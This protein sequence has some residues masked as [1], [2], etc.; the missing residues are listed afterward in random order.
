M[1]E[2]KQIADVVYLQKL[3]L[4]TE[5]VTL[6]DHAKDN[7]MKLRTELFVTGFPDVA[8]SLSK[9]GTFALALPHGW[10]LKAA[11]QLNMSIDEAALPA[12]KEK[13]RTMQVNVDELFKYKPS[14][15]V[16]KY[17]TLTKESRDVLDVILT[18]KRGAVKLE[19]VAPKES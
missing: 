14:I 1:S 19:L 4:W 15:I 9:S 3:R 6:L 2:T 16:A 18:T 10:N 11:L 12:I 8:N 7:E 13:L 17:K 5:S